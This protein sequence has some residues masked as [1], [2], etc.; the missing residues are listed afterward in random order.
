MSNTEFTGERVIPD[1][2]DPNLWNEHMARYAFAS[3]LS[4][5]RRVLDA[6][7]GAGYGTAELAYAAATVTGMDISP[8]AL[9]F[10]REHFARRN[11]FWVQGSCTDLPFRNGSHDL[12][13][14]FE[15][16]EHLTDWAKLIEEA[17]RV[18][19][20]GGQFIVSTPNKSYYAESRRLSGPN[21]FHEHEFEYEEFQDALL[22]VF[23]HVSLFLEDHTEGLLFKAVGSRGSAEVRMEGHDAAPE[24]SNFL[25]AVCAMSPQTGSPT[26]VYLPS[27]A[28]LLKER[29]THI[30]R[31]EHELKTKDSW[32]AES[33]SEHER[34]VQMFREQTAE[35]EKRNEWA[36]E[37]DA[38][39]KDAGERIVELQQ[40]VAET[41]EAAKAVVAKVNELEAEDKIRTQWAL[42]TSAE[43]EAK[44]AELAEC[45]EILNER[46]RTIEE[47]TAWALQLDKERAALAAKL[48]LVQASR[49]V[50]LGRTFGIGPGLQ[51]Q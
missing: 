7:C 16:I 5:N 29:G 31:L 32:L 22:Q 39:L 6:G 21:P 45:V 42:D 41:H 49:W 8:D 26:F 11:V 17:R 18:L 25:I 50:R 1:R 36:Q 35:L 40:E 27:S 9:A 10:A 4:R 15:V 24:D 47:R 23:P 44:C 14:A 51:D 28:N 12:V 38:K 43:L 2:V 30:E 3:R 46:D 37:L 34:L 33:R 13:V 48:D 19:A 20:P